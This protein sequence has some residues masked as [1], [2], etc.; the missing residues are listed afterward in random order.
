MN[1]KGCGKS[2]S[3]T[4]HKKVADW[5]FCPNCFEDLMNPSKP[6]S[7]DT[8]HLPP[9]DVPK[10]ES[11]TCKI[12][13]VEINPENE[14]KLGIWTLCEN[15]HTDLTF[16]TKKKPTPEVA[17]QTQ[18]DSTEEISEI[19]APGKIKMNQTIICHSCGRTILAVA[20]K[21]DGDLAFC[22]D[23]YYNENRGKL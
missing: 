9:K 10:K 23:C 4:D 8:V 7:G 13:G 15:C 20:A 3:E 11:N 6:K 18:K 17:D 19:T 14:I 16:T 12:C 5:T 22:P 21:V 2:I 1:C